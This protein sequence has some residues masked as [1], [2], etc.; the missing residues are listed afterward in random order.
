MIR[1][2]TH[3]FPLIRPAIKLSL[4]SGGGGTLGE[5]IGLTSREPMGCQDDISLPSD[6]S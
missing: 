6:I 5:M 4:I 2:A 3:W 1:A